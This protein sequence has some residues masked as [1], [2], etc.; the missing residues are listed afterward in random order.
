VSRG[1]D[2]SLVAGFTIIGSTEK[3]VLIRG[4]GPGLRGAPFNLTDTLADPTITIYD[5]AGRAFATNDDSPPILVQVYERV[6]AF[7]LAAGSK[8]AALM[9]TVQ[10]GVYSVALSSADGGSGEAMIEIYE[11]R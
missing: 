9:L 3:T 10:P 6:G 1:D 7:P 8:D 11:V 2:S 4:I 5:Q